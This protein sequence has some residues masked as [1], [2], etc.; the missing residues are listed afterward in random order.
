MMETLPVQADHETKLTLIGESAREP[1]FFERWKTR[2]YVGSYNSF[3]RSETRGGCMS[4]GETRIMFT[5]IEEARFCWAM[6]KALNKPSAAQDLRFDY[7][8]VL[9]T[10]TQLTFWLGNGITFFAVYRPKNIPL[11]SKTQKRLFNR[12]HE[13]RHA[14]VSPEAADLL[15]K[16]E[17]AALPSIAATA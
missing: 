13:L 14:Q 4:M 7:H 16:V 5:P 1:T 15:A 11:R 3:M 6:M 10:P 2:R 12:I 9:H 17:R 8:T